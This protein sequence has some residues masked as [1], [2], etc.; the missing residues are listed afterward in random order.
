MGV[1]RVFVGCYLRPPRRF[2]PVLRPLLHVDEATQHC[3]YKDG[4]VIREEEVISEEV[5]IR[6]E[7]VI[8]E[9]KRL[10]EKIRGYKRIRGYQRR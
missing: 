4:E 6:E 5:V 2:P 3:Q 1:W 8:R 7:E 9:D 10:S